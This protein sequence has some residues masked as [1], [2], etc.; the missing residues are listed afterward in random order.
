MVQSI[1]AAIITIIIGA[2][3]FAQSSI[4]ITEITDPQNS[5][6]AG[7]Y[8]ELYNSGTE[9]S[10]FSTREGGWGLQRWTNNYTDPQS[11]E[12]LEGTISA[13]GFFIVCNNYYFFRTFFF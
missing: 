7:R 5:S 10:D 9:D 13:G 2:F 1:H 11:V 3:S 6:T 12:Y 4:F 8:I